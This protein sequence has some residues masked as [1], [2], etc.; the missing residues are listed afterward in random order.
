[1]FWNIENKFGTAADSENFSS[2]ANFIQPD[3]RGRVMKSSF[4]VDFI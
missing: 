2:Y 1:M 3:L 4:A